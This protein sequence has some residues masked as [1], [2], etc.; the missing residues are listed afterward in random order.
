MQGDRNSL[1]LNQLKS[2]FS[3]RKSG[4]SYGDAAVIDHG[5]KWW[6][7]KQYE[8]NLNRRGDSAEWR[9][10]VVSQVRAEAPFPVSGI[11]FSVI[12][13]LEDP[14][15]ESPVFREMQQILNNYGAVTRPIQN[16]TRVRPRI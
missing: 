4:K 11:P 14:N 13:T 3:Y 5:L 8:R 7:C 15:G 10:D 2:R 16:A 1:Y 9:L 12:L 6:P